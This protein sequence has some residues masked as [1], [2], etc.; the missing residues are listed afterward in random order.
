MTRTSLLPDQPPPSPPLKP[1]LTAEERRPREADRRKMAQLRMMI[2]Q[3]LDDQGI[4]NTPVDLGAAFRMPGTAAF[5]LMTGRQWREGEVAMLEAVAVRL[6]LQV[7]WLDPG[8][9]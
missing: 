5:R 3:A 2:W 6:G 7:P 1:K 8:Y 9:P 4:T